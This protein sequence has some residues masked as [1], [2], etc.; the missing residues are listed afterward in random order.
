MS[1]QIIL[2]Q[3]DEVC[4]L[5]CRFGADNSSPTGQC[6]GKNPS[7]NHAFSCDLD[8]LAIVYGRG[9]ELERK[10]SA[11]ALERREEKQGQTE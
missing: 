7:R 4:L 10:R 1:N 9:I 3:T 2:F 5:D 8:A 6:L 11:K